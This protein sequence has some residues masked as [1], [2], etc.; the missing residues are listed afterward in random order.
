M[1]YSKILKHLVLI[2]GVEHNKRLI[3]FLFSLPFFFYM[4]IFH[5]SSNN[6]NEKKQAKAKLSLNHL[7][8]EH[9]ESSEL[10]SSTLVE[11]HNM[12]E[13]KCFYYSSSSS[14]SS[15]SHF[16]SSFHIFSSS[17]LLLTLQLTRTRQRS[18][19]VV[20]KYFERILIV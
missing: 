19:F 9:C 4:Y 12:Y 17:F 15:H 7:L 2:Y 6:N 3:F 16:F 18:I 11:T 1:R 5:F 10:A 8:C 20:K 14:S 13:M